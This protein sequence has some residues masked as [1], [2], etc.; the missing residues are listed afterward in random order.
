MTKKSA[1]L[2]AFLLFIF[3]VPN[4]ALAQSKPQMLKAKIN[5][6]LPVENT[7][8]LDILEKEF[9]LKTITVTNVN[10]A[11]IGQYQT[12]NKIYVNYYQMPNGQEHFELGEPIR[13]TPLIWLLAL[14]AA[15]TLAVA[16]RWGAQSL[17]GL[18][19]S[20]LVI[21]TVILPLLIKGWSPV[22]VSGLG[23][24]LIVPVTFY[25]SHGFSKKTHLAMIATAI[26]LLAVV[27][28]ASL[29]TAWCQFTGLVSEEALF[30]KTSVGSINFRGLLLAGVVIGTLG[31]LDD[32]TIAQAAVVK[33][34]KNANPNLKP[35]DLYKKS[36][37]VGKDHIAS[38]VNTLILVYT[39]ASLPLLL[40]F[41]QSG[42]TATQAL[43]SEIVA[44][45]V[46]KTLVSS[47]GLIL[48]VPVTTALS[49]KFE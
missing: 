23:A 12:G 49:A 16:R 33:Q 17:L 29:F 20:Y 25:L 46:V 22:L 36:M 10:P 35:R 34:L 37:S 5:A 31:I 6:V 24:V 11:V 4:K 47:V 28:L 40:L 19:F 39:G 41:T 42:L 43:N 1:L 26:S 15:L 14:F 13:A 32:I 38:M 30:L 7:V 9:E 45:E 48:A 8:K 3:L 18:L 27:F 21:F 44:L 2:I